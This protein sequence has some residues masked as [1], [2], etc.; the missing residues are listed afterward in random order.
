MEL[1]TMFTYPRILKR[2][3]LKKISKYPCDDEIKDAYIKYLS[4]YSFNEFV[5]YCEDNSGE[6]LEDLIFKF[7]DLQL[8]KFEPNSLIWVSHV[9]INF[10]IYFNVNLDY[11]EFYDA[12]ASAL[13]LTVLS[14]AMEMTISKIPFEEV[15]FPEHS[16]ICFEKLFD[17]CPN[18]KFDLKKDCTLAYNSYNTNFD[19]E[20]EEI[21]SKI[22]A[23]FDECGY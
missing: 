10:M 2:K 18:F 21:Y 19:F 3:D 9:M 5:K 7:T 11:N 4:N 16:K 8:E 17:K 6:N 20:S 13:Q 22:K 12:Y 14:C 15:T 1:I 23:H